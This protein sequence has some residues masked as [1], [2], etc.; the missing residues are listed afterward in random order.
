MATAISASF[1]TLVTVTPNTAIDRVIQVPGFAIGA[2]RRGTRIARLPA[3]KGV[4]CSRVLALLGQRS[5][6][7]GFVGEQEQAEFDHLG[8]GTLINAQFLAVEGSTRENITLL[9]P[10]RHVETHVRTTGFEVHARDVDRLR[11]KLV[12]LTKAGVLLT[13]GGSLPPGLDAGVLVEMVERS[14]SAGAALAL[15]LDGPVLAELRETPAWLVKCNR[16]EFLAAHGEKPDDDARVVEHGRRWSLA[17]GAVIVTCGGAGAYLFSGG[18]AWRGGVDVDPNTVVSTVGCGDA[19]LGGFIAATQ[20]GR[21]VVDAFAFSLAVGSAAATS[22]VPGVFEPATVTGLLQRV[23][24][25][26]LAD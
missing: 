11:R 3:G 6:A 19:L 13:V 4:N 15:D 9:D 12:L 26:P 18:S 2:H 10:E 22:A 7:T 25:E 5:I 16:E 24:L 21:G 17:V 20:Q 23:H 1:Q 14:R 8:D